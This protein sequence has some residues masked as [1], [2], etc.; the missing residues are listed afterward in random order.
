MNDKF[1]EHITTNTSYSAIN[2]CRC[3]ISTIDIDTGVR[4]CIIVWQL[5]ISEYIGHRAYQ[6]YEDS[7]Q[8]ILAF[9]I[10]STLSSGLD[11]EQT[12]FPLPKDIL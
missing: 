5:V 2:N 10:I 4:V 11:L 12:Y 1:N 6:I 7:L 9:I 8:Y 3:S